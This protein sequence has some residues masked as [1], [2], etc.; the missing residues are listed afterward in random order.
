MVGGDFEFVEGACADGIGIS[1]A[2]RFNA[3]CARFSRHAW[4][5][6]RLMLFVAGV[7]L[8]VSGTHSY[9]LGEQVDALMH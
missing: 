3:L 1:L 4:R 7:D 8:S 9:A 6:A 5:K 2:A